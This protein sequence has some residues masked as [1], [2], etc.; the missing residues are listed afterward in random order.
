LTHAD[1]GCWVLKTSRPPAQID[2]SWAPGQDRTL[3]R[4]LHPTYRLDLVAPGQPVLLWVSGR[5][6]AGVHALG[7]VA[8]PV[9]HGPDG[10]VVAVRLRLLAEPVPRADLLADP[11]SRDAEV[12]RVPAGSN[13]S[14]LSPAQR[15]VV[16][17]ALRRGDR[18]TGA[19]WDDGPS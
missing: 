9:D 12:L 13:P 18:P 2:P 4:C 14:W 10:P 11:A 3:D 17:A 7:E 19:A 1:V 5:V 16:L 6:R 15:D 8:G